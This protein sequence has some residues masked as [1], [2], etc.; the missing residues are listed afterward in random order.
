MDILITGASRGLGLE[1]T[2]QY[3]QQ[4]NRV[5]ATCR[6]PKTATE[7]RA[8]QAAFPAHLFIVALEVTDAASRSAA[9]TAI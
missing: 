8:M 4:G 2:R 6:Q 1:A 3:L 9:F 5:F 7:L